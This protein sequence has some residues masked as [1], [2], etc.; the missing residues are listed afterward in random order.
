MRLEKRNGLALVIIGLGILVLFNG[1]GAI[2]FGLSKL[3]GYLIPVLVMLLGY[4]G[5]KNGKT[6]IGGGMFVIGL[7]ILL[8]KLSWLISIIFAL[9]IIAFGFSMLKS[10]PNYH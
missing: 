9:A 6:F 10:K 3:M 2:S 7:I 1:F 8:G 4:V 5:M